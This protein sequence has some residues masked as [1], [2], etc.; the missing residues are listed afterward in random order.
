M[1][2]HDS[3]FSLLIYLFQLAWLPSRSARQVGT[4]LSFIIIWARTLH[5]SCNARLQRPRIGVLPY[6]PGSSFPPICCLPP[7]HCEP[8][9][10]P[11]TGTVAASLSQPAAPPR[12]LALHPTGTPGHS[13]C[14]GGVAVVCPTGTMA[15]KST[16]PLKLRVTHDGNKYDVEVPPESSVGNLMRTLVPITGIPQAGQK[17]ICKGVCLHLGWGPILRHSLPPPPP[18]HTLQIFCC[19]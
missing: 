1:K 4:R 16:K 17:L 14:H 9:R 7:V 3:I 8:R 6:A 2:W 5:R 10:Q 15:T 18:F 11:A 12:P 19:G 13:A